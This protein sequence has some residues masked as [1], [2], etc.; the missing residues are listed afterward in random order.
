MKQLW[1]VY[2]Y[3]RFGPER[4]IGFIITDNSRMCIRAR[5]HIGVDAVASTEIPS[6]FYRNP[7]SIGSTREFCAWQRK[8]NRTGN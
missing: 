7:L 5:T 2:T 8:I 1:H 6:A 3:G 4:H